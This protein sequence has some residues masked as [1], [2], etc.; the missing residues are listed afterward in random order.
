M[1]RERG[2]RGSAGATAVIPL[3]FEPDWETGLRRITRLEPVDASEASAAGGGVGSS[4]GA[5]GRTS[6]GGAA[7]V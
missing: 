5:G 3:P 4:F 2:R 6:L 1:R 7:G